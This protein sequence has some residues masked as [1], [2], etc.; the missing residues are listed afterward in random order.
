MSRI[1]KIRFHEGIMIA[2]DVVRFLP[3][4]RDE[5]KLN[6]SMHLS[7]DKNT[8]TLTD[9][10]TKPRREVLVPIT[11]VV[12]YELDII[13]RPVSPSKKTKNS[14]ELVSDVISSSD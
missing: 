3:L 11:N 7:K 4:P 10:N 2:G 14:S 8:V 5:A 6:I 12:Q 9:N 1:S 13:K